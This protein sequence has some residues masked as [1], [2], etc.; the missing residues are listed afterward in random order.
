MY[1]TLQVLILLTF[2]NCSPNFINSTNYKIIKGDLPVIIVV[3]HD[4]NK[5]F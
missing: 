4:G 2:Y 1:K 3:S 5:K